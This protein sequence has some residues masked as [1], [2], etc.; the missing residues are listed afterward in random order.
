MFVAY[1]VRGVEICITAVSAFTTEEQTLRTPIVASLVLTPGTRLRGMSRIYLDYLHATCLCFIAKEAVELSKAPGV[2]TALSLTFAMGDTLSNIGQILKNDGTARSGILDYALGEDMVVVSSL[3]KQFTRKL[4]QVPFSRLRTFCLELATESEYATFLLFPLPITQELA[5]AGDRWTIK[6]E[7]DTNYFFRLIDNRSRD[8]HNDMEEVAPV[9]EAKISRTD[10]PTNI[11][12]CMFGDGKP[13]LNA[14]R[15]SGKGAGHTFPFDPIRTGIVANGGRLGLWTENRLEFWNR[16]PSLLG[17]LDQL[18]VQSRVFLAPRES[19]FDRFSSLDTGCAYQLSRKVRMLGTQRV[20][21][22]FVQLYP[23]GA[24]RIEPRAC[25]GIEARCVLDHRSIKNGL[26][27][28]RWIQLYDNCSVHT[29]SISYI[30]KIVNREEASVCGQPFFL[31]R[32]KDG[33]LQKG[34]L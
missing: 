20:V 7:V 30:P 34:T 22:A 21:G 2:H 14:P 33:G 6:T 17:F 26:L 18:R 24:S 16:S 28:R 1:V 15:Y 32:L 29:K 12:E 13:D 19:G 10:L 23:I 9:V 8:I 4:L 3:P 27:L 31:P 25:N 5:I 11:L